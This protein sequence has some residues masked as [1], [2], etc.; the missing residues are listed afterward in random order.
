MLGLLLYPV[1]L[2]T[3]TWA[4]IAALNGRWPAET[5]LWPLLAL[6]F[7]NLVAV[8][9]AAVISAVRGLGAAGAR[10]LVWHILFLPF[11]WALMSFAAWQALFQFF[12]RPSE[13]EKTVHGVAR[14]R[15]KRRRPAAL[16][17]SPVAAPA[18]TNGARR[19]QR[20]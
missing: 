18:P 8:L 20:R 9:A 19:R 12:R 2:V 5:H 16:R 10:H 3:V 13:W 14:D 11:Y 6:N 1:S 7:G 15:R 4:V 17:P